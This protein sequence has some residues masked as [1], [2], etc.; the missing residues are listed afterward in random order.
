MDILILNWKDI[1]NPHAGGAEIIAFEFARRLVKEGHKVTFFSRSF[2]GAKKEEAIDGVKILRRGNRITTYVHA[3]FFYR[4]LIKKP[5]KVIDMVN[6]ICWQTP[7][8]VPEDK[9]IVYVNQLAKEVFFFE[10]PIYFAFP[11]FL[12]ERFGY[13]TYRNTKCLCYSSSTKEDLI[14]TGLKKE[15][16]YTFPLGLDHDRYKLGKKK[17]SSPLFIFVSRLVKMKRGDLC[18]KAMGELVKVHPEAKLAIVGN[19]P[20]ENRLEMLVKKLRLSKNVFFVNKDNFFIDKN[21]K[22]IKVKLMQEAWA[23]ILPSVKEGWGMVVTEAAACGTPS[24]VTDVTGLRDSVIK[25]KTGIIISKNSSSSELS[26]AMS[27]LIEDQKL[28]KN[29]SFNAEKRSREFSWDNSYKRFK[30]VLFREND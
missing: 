24:I 10:L 4:S 6:T 13:L 16:I 8:Y 11:S 17:T 19:G 1:K 21:T 15:N 29:L 9:R 30:E 3:Y 14:S 26:A 25:N 7:L 22:D 27:M 20:D 23:L 28:L 12:L 5:D 18:I 2:K